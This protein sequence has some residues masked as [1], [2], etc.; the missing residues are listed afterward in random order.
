MG[1]E[2]NCG[3]RFCAHF[4]CSITPYFPVQS[5]VKTLLLSVENRTQNVPLPTPKLHYGAIFQ[6]TI[7]K[8]WQECSYTTTPHLVVVQNC[9]LVILPLS[10]VLHIPLSS[11]PNWSFAVPSFLPPFLRYTSDRSSVRPQFACSSIYVVSIYLSGI[12]LLLFLEI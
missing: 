4:C 10:P 6:P 11:L 9:T 2:R 8:T 5:C 7:P 3:V 1:W 12:L